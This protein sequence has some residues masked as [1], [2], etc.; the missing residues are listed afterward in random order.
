MTGTLGGLALTHFAE[1][2]SWQG[3]ER[4]PKAVVGWNR[5]KESEREHI[6]VCS[7]GES[8][9][10]LSVEGEAEAPRA[11]RTPGSLE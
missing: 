9:Q 6:G 11:G 1:G 7:G 8:D 4:S 5:P 3:L 2:E 10:G